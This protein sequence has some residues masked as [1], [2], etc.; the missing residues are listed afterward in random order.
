MWGLEKATLIE[1]QQSEGK[2]ETEIKRM[3]NKSTRVTKV[4]FVMLM[5]WLF[6]HPGMGEFNSDDHYIYYWAGIP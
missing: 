5:R 1:E 2:A 6:K 3:S 4:I